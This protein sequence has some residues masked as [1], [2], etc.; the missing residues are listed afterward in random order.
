MNV[1]A[2]AIEAAQDLPRATEKPDIQTALDQLQRNGIAVALGIFAEAFRNGI[3]LPDERVADVMIEVAS[4]VISAFEAD[5][6]SADAYRFL[7]TVAPE[8]AEVIAGLLELANFPSGQED[9]AALSEPIML[10][11]AG[12]LSS[13]R[14]HDAAIGILAR[15]LDK[16]P[17]R[18]GLSHAMAIA[19]RRQ[20]GLPDDG[21]LTHSALQ[22]RSFVIN[23]DRQPAKY[24]SFLRRN[25]ASKLGFERL[26]ASDGSRMSDGEVMAQQL[27]A[28]GTRFTRGAV[29]CAASHRLVWSWVA[30]QGV[31]ALVFEDD[32]TVRHDLNERLAELLPALDNWDYVTLGYNIDSVLDIEFAPGMKS[33]MAFS[34]QHPNDQTD[35]DFQSSTTPVAAFRLNTC[36][37]TPGYAVSPSGARKLLQLCFPMDNR[38]YK[39]PLLGREL[40]VVGIDGM[41]NCIYPSVAAYACFAP[42]VMPR[43]DTATSTTI[44]AADLRSW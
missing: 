27:V 40:G 18:Q 9:P 29:G 5:R 24:E 38:Q 20:A 19:R 43:N 26:S 31:P 37:G 3:D 17:D 7:R 16:A 21:N 39:V 30:E 10:A 1:T 6:Q 41:M 33:M 13:A 32:A 8:A 12:A 4:A 14:R 2:T 44:Q 36:F 25:A 35:A 15:L 11:Y 22:M 23:L 28:P 42:L 34:P